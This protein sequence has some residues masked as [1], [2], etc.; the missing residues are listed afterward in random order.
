MNNFWIRKSVRHPTGI[1]CDEPV[2]GLITVELS[3]NSADDEFVM[4]DATS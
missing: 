1:C 4:V 2:L 3:S